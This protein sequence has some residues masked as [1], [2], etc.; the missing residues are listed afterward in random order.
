MKAF[1]TILCV[2]MIIILISCTG[3]TP[4]VDGDAVPGAGENNTDAGNTTYEP[5]TTSDQNDNDVEVPVE[6]EP[7]V[8][9]ETE[10][11]LAPKVDYWPNRFSTPMWLSYRNITHSSAVS[12]PVVGD[13]NGDGYDEVASFADSYGSEYVNGVSV[14][15][16]EIMA[17]ID[18]MLGRSYDGGGTFIANTN[19]HGLGSATVYKAY[20]VGTV[21]Y[22]ATSGGLGISSDGLTFTNKTVDDGLLYD[23]VLDVAAVDSGGT[24]YVVG[25]TAN[26]ISFSNN[27]GTSFTERIQNTYYY[28]VHTDGTQ[29]YAGSADSGV[30]VF[31]AMDGS[32]YDIRDTST[33]LGS[34]TVRDVFSDGAKI[35]A[36][37]A[38]GL[39]ISS[40][41]TGTSFT[42]F[43]TDNGLAS[44]FVQAVYVSVGKVYAGTSG[45]LTICDTDGSNC[46]NR[47]TAQGLGSNDIRDVYVSGND[48]YAA[49][50]NGLSISTNS[51]ASFSNFTIQKPGN[52]YFGI[53]LHIIRPEEYNSNGHW[54]LYSPRDNENDSSLPDDGYTLAVPSKIDYV[55]PVDID[56]DG[57]TDIVTLSE[58]GNLNL[59]F[60]ILGSSG[61]IYSSIGKGFNSNLFTYRAIES[62]FL[63]EGNFKIADQE[64]NDFSDKVVLLG[65]AAAS[66]AYNDLIMVHDNCNVFVSLYEAEYNGVKFGYFENATYWGDLASGSDCTSIFDKRKMLIM[67]MDG[68]N[69]DGIVFANGSAIFVSSA[70]ESLGSVSSFDNPAN[71][72]T[73]KESCGKNCQLL[74]GHFTCQEN[75]EDLAQVLYDGDNKVDKI[76]VYKSFYR[77]L[78]D[79]GFLDGELWFSVESGSTNEIPVNA[80]YGIVKAGN[81]KNEHFLST[82]INGTGECSQILI[83]GND[84]TANQGVY[85]LSPKHSSQPM[86]SQDV[87]MGELTWENA[88]SNTRA[89]SGN[90]GGDARDDLLI[91]T[92]E[93]SKD[94]QINLFL[95]YLDVFQ[96]YF[97]GSYYKD[98]SWSGFN[99]LNSNTYMAGDF[100]DDGTSEIMRVDMTTNKNNIAVYTPDITKTGF[101]KQT[102]P[103]GNINHEYYSILDGAM[104][105]MFTGDMNSDGATDLLRISLEPDHLQSPVSV[106]VSNLPAGEDITTLQMDETAALPD[107]ANEGDW[108]VVGDY[109]GDGYSDVVKVVKNS[110][111]VYRDIKVYTNNKNGNFE[112]GWST[113]LD[114]FYLDRGSDPDS[115]PVDRVI[116]G[117]FNCDG[118]FDLLIVRQEF[119]VWKAY[120]MLSNG[121]SFYSPKLWHED[122][123]GSSIPGSA[124]HRLLT[125]GNYRGDGC[126]NGIIR[127]VP[128]G[129]NKFKVFFTY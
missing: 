36:A 30:F 112:S 113:T 60:S 103:K 118:N 117:D 3:K 23:D 25:A 67:N 115:D 59:G 114:A 61:D 49:T 18:G 43:T 119:G 31:D 16:S 38:S 72:G 106:A 78:S 93:T 58:S 102:G 76:Y 27:G 29:V 124:I 56:R 13:F 10:P 62:N 53:T 22:A 125:V 91:M 55:Y 79:F 44:N 40:D 75:R 95:S 66:D 116:P 80:N 17:S 84:A 34:N 98:W 65:R 107:F 77:N 73:L 87:Y 101:T 12:D 41:T 9:D 2:L 120:V 111:G 15:G 94:D 71:V 126:M 39:S 6:P 123:V 110:D 37:T 8:V 109:N 85:M 47:T 90:F 57:K 92:S 1:V 74:K 24:V 54:R 83:S 5:P 105:L 11:F 64:G 82:N 89:M 128:N 14:S 68:S 7:V 99:I 46:E 35:F 28:S 104:G 26:G 108:A 122:L 48:V 127:L 100:N 21:Y 81:F 33:G 32:S 50:T 51:G 96:P 4:Y 20:K 63:D 42:N 88:L 97:S 45:G 19:A 129:V 69:K 52:E 70:N 121:S 86:F